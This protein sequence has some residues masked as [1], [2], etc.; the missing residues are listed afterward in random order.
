MIGDEVAEDDSDEDVL[1]VSELELVF[2]VSSFSR[3]NSFALSLL[4]ALD[5]VGFTF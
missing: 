1:E 4:A 5:V 2:G 3:S